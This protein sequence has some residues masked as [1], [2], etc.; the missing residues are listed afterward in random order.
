MADIGVDVPS[1]SIPNPAVQD[2]KALIR[3]ALATK[4]CIGEQAQRITAC[5]A[6]APCNNASSEL[7]PETH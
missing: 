1:M 3:C 5:C 6:E 2:A 4:R 7:I